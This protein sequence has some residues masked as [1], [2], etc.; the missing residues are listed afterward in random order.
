M[1]KHEA[2]EAIWVQDAFYSLKCQSREYTL[3]TKLVVWSW[4]QICTLNS[5]SD[6]K[7]LATGQ[8]RAH[9]ICKK[10]WIYL[11]GMGIRNC[12]KP[13]RAIKKMDTQLI[14]SK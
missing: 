4:S 8:G 11:S 9:K 7:Y 6:E 3:V 2:L 12:T 14:R 1:M 10:W 13:R 5:Y